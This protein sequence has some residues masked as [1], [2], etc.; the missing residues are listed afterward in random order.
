MP[1]RPNFSHM[2]QMFPIRT[3][4]FNSYYRRNLEE[5]SHTTDL[6]KNHYYSYSQEK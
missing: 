4:V 1:I 6:E 3:F 5:K 2:L